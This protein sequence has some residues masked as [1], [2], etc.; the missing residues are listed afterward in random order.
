MSGPS[1]Q[2]ARLLTAGVLVAGLAGLAVWALS[3]AGPRRGP[4]SPDA[5]GGAL[6]EVLVLRDGSVFADGSVG[7]RAGDRRGGAGD[8][9]DPGQAETFDGR[10]DGAVPLDEETTPPYAPP[11]DVVRLTP[12]ELNERRLQQVGLIEQRIDALTDQIEAA[13]PDSSLRGILEV[14]REHLE[15]RRGELLSAVVGEGVG[16]D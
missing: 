10:T 11:D 4:G 3:G 12:E 14:R 2:R 8:R 9:D 15:E 1:S 7:A 13:P 6:P 16:D 5:R